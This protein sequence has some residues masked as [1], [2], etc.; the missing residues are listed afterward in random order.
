M[1]ITYY[2]YYIRTSTYLH[3]CVFF[4]IVNE[5]SY[6]VCYRFGRGSPHAIR[7]LIN[8]IELCAEH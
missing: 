2:D 3:L 6:P 7:E 4:C 8:I 1:H 5:D